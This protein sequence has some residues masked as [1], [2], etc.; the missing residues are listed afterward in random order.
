MKTARFAALVVFATLLSPAEVPAQDTAP[1]RASPPTER[2]G[3]GEQLHRL[4]VGIDRRLAHGHIS[5]HDAA[6]AHREL[7][8]IQSDLADVRL[9]NGG[10]VPSD[11]HFRLQDRVNKLSEKIDSERTGPPSH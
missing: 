6:A 4:D 8:D 9:R 11:E 2:N 10:Q 7:Y 5:R 1:P 3:L